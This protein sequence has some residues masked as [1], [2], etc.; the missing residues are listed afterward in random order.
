M[1][2]SLPNNTIFDGS[3]RIGT[4]FSG[5]NRINVVKQEEQHLEPQISR[6]RKGA[7]LSVSEP[8]SISI[9]QGQ[10]GKDFI[11]LEN[12]KRKHIRVGSVESSKTESR[13]SSNPRGIELRFGSK[14][15]TV[16]W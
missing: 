12:E 15:D 3:G 9:I 16:K 7:D 4:D 10:E 1:E 6:K 2:I 13:G 5:S 8:S 14:P 11:V